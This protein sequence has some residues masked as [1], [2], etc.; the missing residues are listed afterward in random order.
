VGAK[1]GYRQVN[2]KEEAGYAK[3]QD[4]SEIDAKR[5]ALGMSLG[6][7]IRDSASCVL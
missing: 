4:G 6:V 1:V 5:Q 2:R 3:T 7:G